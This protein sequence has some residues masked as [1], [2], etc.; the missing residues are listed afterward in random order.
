MMFELEKRD[1]A[2]GDIFMSELICL[3][4]PKSETGSPG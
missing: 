4:Q 2:I 3:N 1:T